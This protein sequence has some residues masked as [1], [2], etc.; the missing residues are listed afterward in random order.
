[1]FA[2]TLFAATG[3]TT[4]RLTTRTRSMIDFV[5]TLCPPFLRIPVHVTV[6][7]STFFLH[8][9]TRRKAISNCYYGQVSPNVSIKLIFLHEMAFFCHLS[10]L[11]LS[12]LAD[13]SVDGDKNEMPRNQDGI[14]QTK[15]I[16]CWFD[17]V[18]QVFHVYT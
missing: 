12:S 3:L 18:V 16:K 1:M 7:V 13:L 9:K 14:Q 10:P 15:A 11:G 2:A 8:A 17:V 4:K 5:F 6:R